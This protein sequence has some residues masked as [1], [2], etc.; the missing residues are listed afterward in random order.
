MELMKYNR[1]CRVLVAGRI[2]KKDSFGTL[3]VKNVAKEP[4]QQVAF[5]GKDEITFHPGR[6]NAFPKA[7]F[8]RRRTEYI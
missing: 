1:F 8:P 4:L 2:G 7:T 6:D 5:C 3:Y